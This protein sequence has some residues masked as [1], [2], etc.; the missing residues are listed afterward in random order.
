MGLTASK[1]L[2]RLAAGLVA[3]LLL[4]ACG[5]SDEGS[6][7]SPR[8]LVG[9][10]YTTSGKRDASYSQAA[11]L[12]VELA[13]RRLPLVDVKEVEPAQLSDLEPTLL[14]LSRS[15]PK[16]VVAV[17]FFYAEP[18]K[19]VAAQFRGVKYVIIDGEVIE[20]N[21]KSI[22]FKEEQGSFLV[23]A[24][25]AMKSENKKIGVVTAMDIPILNKF[26]AGYISGASAID[27]KTKVFCNFIGTGPD[28]FNDPLKGADVARRLIKEQ[29]VDVI[30]QVAGASGGGIINA[31]KDAGIFAIGVDSNQN[32]L[33]PG[34]VL[35]S[36]LKRVDLAVERSIDDVVSGRFTGGVVRLG[37]ER[38]GPDFVD[39]AVDSNNERLITAN[40]RDKVESLKAMIKRGA[41]KVP[42]ALDVPCPSVGRDK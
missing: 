40:V 11:A 16:V 7:S 27:P 33:A 32:G 1:S 10:A 19:R 5:K 35:T 26:V 8:I 39:Y 9:V 42:Q 2:T 41:I 13:K 12:G 18:V 37:L 36:M 25:A 15:K 3:V 28:S 17:S 31:A 38:E 20:E 14:A 29:G 24:I 4:S 6:A 30:Y 22:L 34:T 23:G 21:V